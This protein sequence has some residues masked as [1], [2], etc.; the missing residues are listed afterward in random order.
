MALSMRR[1]LAHSTPDPFTIHSPT[2][3]SLYLI[4]IPF[5]LEAMAQMG[6]QQDQGH[7]SVAMSSLQ[8]FLIS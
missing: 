4:P 2:P 7:G 1:S 6:A 5:P 8:F 3:T